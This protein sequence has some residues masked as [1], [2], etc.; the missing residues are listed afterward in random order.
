MANAGP[1]FVAAVFGRVSRE[2]LL[3]RMIECVRCFL[4]N[5]VE[6]K[7]QGRMGMGKQD[8][9]GHQTE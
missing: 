2:F 9:K 5:E 6:E 1:R 8:E 4:S 7:Y 3:R